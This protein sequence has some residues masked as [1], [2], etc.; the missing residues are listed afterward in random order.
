MF[1]TRHFVTNIAS[2]SLT[3]LQAKITAAASGKGK[4]LHVSRVDKHSQPEIVG[5]RMYAHN[6]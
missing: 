6:V 1:A 3:K 5:K 2:N 4:S